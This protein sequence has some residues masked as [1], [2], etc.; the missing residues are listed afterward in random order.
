MRD[1]LQAAPIDLALLEQPEEALLAQLN[2]LDFVVLLTVANA[3]QNGIIGNDN[4]VTGAV[5][6][7]SLTGAGRR[8]RR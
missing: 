3:V 1:R 2:A 6:G 8:R 4:S 7:S 5:I